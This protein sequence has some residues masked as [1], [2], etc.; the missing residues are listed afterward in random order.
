M[1]A[2]K[3]IQIVNGAYAAFG[4]GDIQGL[5]ALFAEDIEWI[6]PGEEWLLA[7]TYRGRAEVA[8]FFKKDSETSLLNILQPLSR[9]SPN[10]PP[11]SFPKGGLL[12][13]CLIANKPKERPKRL[14]RQTQAHK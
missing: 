6:I 4:R 12:A 13:N 3:N 8:D 9:N 14:V 10:W 5:L 1:S 11:G 7:G 2:Q